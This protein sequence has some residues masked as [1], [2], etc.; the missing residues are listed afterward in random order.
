M[1]RIFPTTDTPGALEAGA[2]DYIDR[3]LA[4]PYAPDRNLYRE[5]C[6]AL[7]RRARERYGKAFAKLAPRQCD[8]VLR[9][10]EQGRVADFP[11]AA[12]FFT[13][14]WRHT[15]EGIFGEPAYGGN[16]DMIGWRLVGF[17]GQRAGYEDLPRDQPIE[18]E[19]H[20]LPSGAFDPN[21]QL[22]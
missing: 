14:L 3:A 11:R 15:M 5:G 21:E 8:A 22:K 4:G 6:R 2:D 16:R 7:N 18:L 1:A 17:P 13:T 9:E 20:T 12:Q 10:F 19:P